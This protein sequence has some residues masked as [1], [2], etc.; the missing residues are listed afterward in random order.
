MCIWKEAF[1]LHES[2][3]VTRVENIKDAICIDSHWSVSWT[4][5]NKT[6]QAETTEAVL[7]ALYEPTISVCANALPTETNLTGIWKKKKKKTLYKE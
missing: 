5:R 3:G 7:Y 4:E 1:S 2:S 6:S